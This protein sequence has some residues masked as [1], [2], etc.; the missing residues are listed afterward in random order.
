[1]GI[2]ALI[3]AWGHLH[4][5]TKLTDPWSFFVVPDGLTRGMRD[6][7]KPMLPHPPKECDSGLT[8]VRFW[9]KDQ[10]EDSPDG[11]GVLCFN[12]LIN[13]IAINPYVI[14][15]FDRDYYL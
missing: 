7:N 5:Q 10:P 4:T 2:H 11:G 14:L 9:E 8:L 6:D 1:M 12:G 3:D 15:R 13:L